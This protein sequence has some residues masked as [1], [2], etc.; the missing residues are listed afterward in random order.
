MIVVAPGLTR[1]GSRCTRPVD[2]STLYP[3]LLELCSLPADDACDGTSIVPLLK[4]PTTAW[5]CPAL[6]TY[7]RG[8]HAVRSERW[9]YIHYADGTEELYDH[10]V[11]PNEWTNMAGDPKYAPVIA[12]HRR[13]LPKSEAK[14]APDMKKP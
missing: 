14:A 9:R 11:D 10:S 13:W 8:N 2:L 1:P 7:M 4:D 6:M 12:E 3:T 5:D